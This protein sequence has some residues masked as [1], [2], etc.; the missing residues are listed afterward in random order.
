V[1]TGK[2]LNTLKGHEDGV[3]SVGFSLDGQQLASGSRDKTIKIWDVTTGKDLNT[4]KGH[5]SGVYSVGFSPDG[6]KLASGSDD[7][8]IILWDLNLDNLVISGCNLLN[9]YLIG[10]PQVLVELKDCQTPSRLSLAATV[11]VIQGENLAKNDDINRALDNFR[12]AKAWDKS[13][14]FDPQAKAEEFANKGQAK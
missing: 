10:N 6:Q 5:E 13:L 8:T 2:V 7:N 4:L 9:N 3:W 11:L 12:Q 14:Q 1:T